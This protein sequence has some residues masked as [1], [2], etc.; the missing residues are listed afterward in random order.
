[1]TVTLQE[2]FE[3]PELELRLSV[4]TFLFCVRFFLGFFTGVAYF[5]H[6]SHSTVLLVV[7]SLLS[8][9]ISV[10]D[11]SFCVTSALEQMDGNSL[12]EKV[13]DPL[14]SQDVKKGQNIF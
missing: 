13:N 5:L 7:S 9:S 12:S 4:E 10:S 11:F 8:S 3:L 1:M 2:E 14:Y 6:V